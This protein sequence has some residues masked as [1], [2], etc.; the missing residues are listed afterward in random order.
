MRKVRYEK[1]TDSQSRLMVESLKV[2]AS[3][4][5]WC[6]LCLLTLR[7]WTSGGIDQP[8]HHWVIPHNYWS[9]AQEDLQVFMDVLW[10]LCNHL[11]PMRASILIDVIKY[12]CQHQPFT[13][14]WTGLMQ[15][16]LSHLYYTAT[17]TDRTASLTQ[18]ASELR[19]GISSRA[20]ACKGRSWNLNP[21]ILTEAL[22]FGHYTL[23][24]P[25]PED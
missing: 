18:G 5:P 8:G 16:M 15:S 22:S 1:G 14:P 7:L 13:I 19:E 17:P 2:Q 21:D 11:L 24:L 10:S 20:T 3:S 9:R 12:N 6:C 23:P 4:C 25:D